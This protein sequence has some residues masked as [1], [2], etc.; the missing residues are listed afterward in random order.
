MDAVSQAAVRGRASRVLIVEH[1]DHELGALAAI[2]KDEGFDTIGC[3]SAAEALQYVRKE[4]IAVAIVDPSL[5]ASN[6]TELLKRFQELGN[7][8]PV[9]VHTAHASYESAKHAINHGAFGYV[10]K[11][12]DPDEIVYHVRRAFQQ[13][14]EQYADELEVAVAARTRELQDACEELGCEINRRERATEALARSESLLATILETAPAGVGLLHDRVFQWVNLPMLE[15]TG[16]HVDDLLGQN[17]Q[18]LYETVEEYERVGRVKYDQ[19]RATGTGE[20][21]TQWRRKD[22]KIIH[23]HLRSTAV[24]RE[25]LTAGVIFTATDITKR[26]QAERALRASEAKYR[27]MF[28]DSPEM[29]VLI[30]AQGRLSETN[31]RAIEWLGYADEDFHGKHFTKLPIWSRKDKAR[32]RDLFS[33]RTAGKQIAPYDVDF[34]CEDGSTLACRVHGTLVKDTVGEISH[35]LMMVS[36]VSQ[37]KKMEAALRESEEQYRDLVEMSPDGIATLDLRGKITSSNAAS[38]Q[39]L[40]YTNDEVLGQPFWRLGMLRPKDV[41]KYLRQFVSVIRGKP[42]PPLEVICTDK[43]G[44]PHTLECRLRLIRTDGRI[45][46]LQ[47]TSRDVTDRKQAERA[48]RAARDQAQQYLDIARVM[49][50]ALDGNGNITLVNRC[51]CELLGYCEEDLIGTSWFETCLPEAIRTQ[52]RKVYQRLMADEVE[53]SE[54]YENPVLTRDG[55][56]RLIAWRNTILRDNEGMIVGTLNSGEDITER[57]EAHDALRVSEA[58]LRLLVE[59]SPVGIVLYRPDGS[60][61]Y[62]NP[63][64]RKMHRLSEEAQQYLLANYNVLEDA[65]LDAKGLLRYIKRAFEGKPVTLPTVKY[66]PKDSA[67]TQSLWE[68]TIWL[69][70]FVYPVKDEDGRLQEVVVVHNDITERKLTEERLHDLEAEMAHIGRVHT[71]GEMAATLAHEIN[72]PLYSIANYVRGVKRRINREAMDFDQL[73]DVM[74]RVSNEVDRAAG[75]ISRLREFVRKGRPRRS[76]VYVAELVDDVMKLLEP[77][78]HRNRITVYRRLH[79]DIPTVTADSVQI[80]QVVVNLV[81]NAMDAMSELPDER[82]VLTIAVKSAEDANI[83]IAVSDNGKGLPS[84][85]ADSVFEPFFTTKDEG[86]GIG[87]AIS[88]T[89]VEAHGG[90]LWA[91]PNQ[92]HGTAFS[93]TIPIMSEETEDELEARSFPRG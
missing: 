56:E 44:A 59:Q 67:I 25:D 35:V 40:G 50:V 84:D 1:D 29:I 63:A 30:D 68:Q 53:P 90:R 61:R 26:K 16:Y 74:D 85:I 33:Q 58:R 66:D 88:R 42:T 52:V 64:A 82:R 20:I 69:D 93:F 13:H 14:L 71:V 24:D 36:D 23:V 3:S 27:S 37:Q 79:D 65:Q 12:C 75:I 89:I 76:T 38:N 8:V 39:L 49:F 32:L 78:I 70:S 43:T 80:R 19:I 62:A 15:M 87:L 11:A 81:R 48:L 47:V 2:L 77:E 6:G 34:I 60:V 72:Q 91:A 4:N 18:M 7:N 45:V 22:G 10:E 9:V 57:K 28:E 31:G 17:A 21:D 46:G 41:P 73:V 55:T 51:S 83:E 86:L 5:P 54:Y 92:P